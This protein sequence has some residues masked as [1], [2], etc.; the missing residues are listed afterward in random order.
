MNSIL[1][2]DDGTRTTHFETAADGFSTL[3]SL[4]F[5]ND[6]SEVYLSDTIAQQVNAFTWDR[7]AKKLTRKDDPYVSKGR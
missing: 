3:K 1:N 7:D 4:A 6:G 2:E 5:N